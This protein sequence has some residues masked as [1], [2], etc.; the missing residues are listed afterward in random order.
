MV[1]DSTERV[2]D[3]S[4]EDEMRES[5]LDYAMSVI[6]SRA[7][8]DVR[9]GLKPVQRRVLFGAQE[10]G[11]GPTSSFKKTAR[12][13]GDVMG[14]LHPHGDGAIYDAL[15]R[16]GQDFSLRYPL[17]TPQGNFGSVDG[18]PPAQMRY[19]E[20]RLAPIAGELLADLDR[21]TVDFQPN[22]DDSINEPV[23]LPARI[24][25]MLINGSTG[26]AVG[27]A[28]NIPPHNLVEI[29]D[30]IVLVLDNPD[31]SVD[32]L[33]EIVHGPDFPTA[34]TIYNREQTRQAYATG[35]GKITMR[36]RMD[37]EEARAGRYQI[38]VTEL[39]YQ[40]NKATLLERIAA[41]VRSK[42]LD[43]I[44]DLRD[45][46]DRHGMRMVIE[47]SRNAQYQ[48]VRA[49]L[50]KHTA[51]QSTFAVN[52]LALVDD[53][54]RVITLREALQAFVD[55]RREVIRRRSEFDLE[56]AR[57]RAHVLEGLLTA[58]GDLDRVIATIRRA[59]SADAR[60][61]GAD[62]PPA[63]PLRPPGAGGAG[64]AAAPP[65]P[66][67]A[68]ADRDRARRAQRAHRLPRGRA[69]QP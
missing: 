45:E 67:R 51:L 7:L 38:V 40:V 29:C 24:P 49:Q 69:R 13:V 68:R 14:K 27:M 1:Q 6:V 25:N 23:V 58:L 48:S 12:L 20:A 26:I 50:F 41:L 37:F 47:L 2:R 19:T 16:M 21:N 35:R 55:H 59:R 44:S 63:Q 9:D 31:C 65:R 33:L 62:A 15:V 22:F 57:E 8:P 61:D 36:A 42:R 66:P 46:S 34:A 5:Y 3:I 32:D 10:L 60:E 18:D 54:P 28:T 4:I 30:G 39:P 17:I 11:M 52:M 43:G 64:H 56:K 53:Q